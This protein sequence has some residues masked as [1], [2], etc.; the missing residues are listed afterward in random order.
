M[1]AVILF[2]CPGCNARIK[3]PA[4]LVGQWRNCP[5][6]QA[7]FQVR[8]R[9]P[10]DSAPVLVPEHPVREAAPGDAASLRAR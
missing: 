3:A 9:P 5:G 4:Q 1:P 10:Q 6:C 7:R 2:R 8:P